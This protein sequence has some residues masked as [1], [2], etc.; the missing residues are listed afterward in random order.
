MV[1]I[2]STDDEKKFEFYIYSFHLSNI[3]LQVHFTVYMKVI[4]IVF[5]RLYEFLIF[6][7][8]K[9]TQPTPDCTPVSN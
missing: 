3:I 9:L 8:F 2:Q 1:R 7:P 5:L 6:R 4:V